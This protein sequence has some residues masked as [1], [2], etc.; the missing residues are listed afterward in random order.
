MKQYTFSSFWTGKPL[1]P[2]EFLSMKSF[3]CNGYA[4]RIYSY[5]PLG[6]LPSGVE[7]CDANEILPKHQLF[8]HAPHAWSADIFR[9]FLLA[10]RPEIW[11]DL[12]MVC[13]R[14]MSF[15]E[16]DYVLGRE[17]D[18]ASGWIANIGIIKVP[19]RSPLAIT[20]RDRAQ[21]CINEQ[22]TKLGAVGVRIFNE[23][24]QELGLV[25]KLC[26]VDYFYKIH[27]TERRN[28]FLTAYDFHRHIL[29]D[30][31]CFAVHFWRGYLTRFNELPLTPEPSSLYGYLLRRYHVNAYCVQ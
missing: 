18:S 16:R 6:E 30:A 22:L 11:V 3:V 12:D 14:P 7:H 15:L 19:E 24:V 20:L 2:L 4:F 25:G 29:E 1:G 9:F 23:K 31:E 26:P 13:I 5:E 28:L 21:L 10:T 8:E 17:R 27:Y